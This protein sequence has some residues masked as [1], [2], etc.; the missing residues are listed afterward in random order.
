MFFLTLLILAMIPSGASAAKINVKVFNMDNDCN[1]LL[2]TKKM[3]KSKYEQIQKLI[4]FESTPS[5]PLG[6]VSSTE[7]LKRAKELIKNNLDYLEKSVKEIELFHE[8]RW[9]KLGQYYLQMARAEHERQM[10][11]LTFMET[12]NS[13]PLLDGPNNDDLAHNAGIEPEPEMTNARREQLFKAANERILK[14]PLEERDPYFLTCDQKLRILADDKKLER[15]SVTFA[16]YSCANN[17]D[18]Q[19]CIKKF[20]ITKDMAQSERE[21]RRMYLF[22]WAW[23]NNEVCHFTK[24]K[25]EIPSEYLGPRLEEALQ[26]VV[27]DVKCDESCPVD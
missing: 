8:A 17:G 9:K 10:A 13:A 18:K 12:W 22:Q 21:G 1:G 20:K 15:F 23:Y 6:F 27:S 4:Y 2:D 14:L 3:S 16:P 19:E 26:A 25:T 5:D 7:E 24:A 11:A